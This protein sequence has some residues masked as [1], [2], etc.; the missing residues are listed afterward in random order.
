MSGDRSAMT[1]ASAA[2]ALVG[3]LAGCEAFSS[4]EDIAVAPE[5]G[6]TPTNTR[7]AAPRSVPTTQASGPGSGIS[8]FGELNDYQGVPFAAQAAHGLQQHTFTREGADFDPEVDRTGRLLIFA[9]TR[10][11]TRPDIYVKAIGG[12]AVTQLTDDPASDVQ[13]QISPNGQWVAFASDRGGNWDIWI[14][15][16]DGQSTQQLTK[17]PKAE[18][19][20][21]WS[22]DGQRLVYCALNSQTKEWELW[23]LDLQQPGLQKYIGNGLFPRWSPKDDVIVY[24]RARARGKRW[25]G[26]WTLRLVNGEP[27]FPTEIA[28]SDEHALIA[29]AWTQNGERVVYCAVGTQ[30]P[31]GSAAS[32]PSATGEVWITDANG[33]GR[34]RITHGPAV[35]YSPACGPNG[36]VYF[37]SNRSGTENIWSI[38]PIQPPAP[39]ADARSTDDAGT[40]AGP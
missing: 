36:L 1:F 35:N 39:V 8:L 30:S 3:L 16:I 26:I 11:F 20:P 28:S 15:S 38:A 27:R 17:S 13:P 23:V 31:D 19:H 7:Q 4:S 25:F 37:A 34:I 2:M 29:P 12:A 40:K 32:N 33:K 21:S 22:Q 14:T 24:Q 10:H 5:L 9:S 18:V 6:A